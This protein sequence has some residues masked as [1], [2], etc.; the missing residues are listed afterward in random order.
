MVGKISRYENKAVGRGGIFHPSFSVFILTLPW[1]LVLEVKIKTDNTDADQSATQS[2]ALVPNV[3]IGDYL[4]AKN[5]AIVYTLFVLF[6]QLNAVL[7][8]ALTHV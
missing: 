2:T 3:R 8:G 7:L 6:G 5:T 1:S 4:D